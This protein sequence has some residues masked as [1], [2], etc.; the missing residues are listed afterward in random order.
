MGLDLLSVG[1]RLTLAV[2]AS[3]TTIAAAIAMPETTDSVPRM[4]AA[5]A[6]GFPSR[7]KFFRR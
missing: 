2:L 3:A 7:V 5:S 6:L 1:G 4:V